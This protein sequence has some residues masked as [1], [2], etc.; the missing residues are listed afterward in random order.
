[1]D[2]CNEETKELVK[3]IKSISFRVCISITSSDSLQSTS[4]RNQK[5]IISAA[6]MREAVPYPP[7]SGNTTS[8]DRVYDFVC[9]LSGS[10]HTGTQ[11]W[12]EGRE[13]VKLFGESIEELK[14]G[15]RE[16]RGISV[17][18]TRPGFEVELAVLWKTSPRSS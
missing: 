12:L 17:M 6:G 5:V 7:S 14:H 16:D 1:M 15:S 9:W 10:R 3:G 13:E 8:G 18:Q 2:C 11:H 4:T